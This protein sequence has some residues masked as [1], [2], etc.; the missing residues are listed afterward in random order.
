MYD[1][2]NYLV[3]SI[4]ELMNFNTSS[5]FKEIL[6]ALDL[7]AI[8]GYQ[9][10]LEPIYFLLFPKGQT[11]FNEIVAQFPTL[12]PQDSLGSLST[13]FVA[14]QLQ[15]LLYSIW[16][17]GQSR[18]KAR[19]ENH[20]HVDISTKRLKYNVED[21]I[22]TMYQSSFIL[23][24]ETFKEYFNLEERYKVANERLTEI[25]IKERLKQHLASNKERKN[26]KRNPAR[27]QSMECEVRSVLYELI[28][29]VVNSF[30][31]QEDLEKQALEQELDEIKTALNKIPSEFK[32][33]K[34]SI[35]RIVI[36]SNKY[37][38]TDLR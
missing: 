8:H 11:S 4:V 20:N 25:K 35:S 23:L 29:Q 31:T 5:A 27:N 36:K 22:S 14:Y 34:R 1:V 16:W 24:N 7:L 15:G 10:I 38:I 6:L 18:D 19:D 17:E 9:I 37:H 2:I 21:V 13:N 30:P 26:T 12:L 3:R 32:V 33:S 28:D